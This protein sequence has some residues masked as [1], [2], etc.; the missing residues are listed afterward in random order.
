MDG[1]TMMLKSFG[2]D[3]EKLKSELKTNIESVT[4]RVME[5]VES[6][7]ASQKRVEDK[8]D[9]IIANQNA[10]DR[11]LVLVEF[12]ATKDSGALDSMN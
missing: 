1:L 8:L 2:L 11:G 7:E 9:K 6:I 12:D 3:P 10:L 4:A 5:R